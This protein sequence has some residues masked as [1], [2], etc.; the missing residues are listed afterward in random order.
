MSAEREICLITVPGGGGKR[1]T[2]ELTRR[3]TCQCLH[4]G[5]AAGSGYSPELPLATIREAIR[6][7]REFGVT[8]VYFTGGEPL[9]REDIYDIF[10]CASIDNAL[11]IYT[12]TNGDI[13]TP[14]V[15]KKLVECNLDGVLVSIDSPD[16]AEHNYFRQSANNFSSACA[17]VKTLKTAGLAV[18]IGMCLWG[19]TNRMQ[20]MVELAIELGADEVTFIW[21]VPVGRAACYA[22]DLLFSYEQYAETF[23]E[24]RV[25]RAKNAGK[26]RLSA[27]RVFD[28]A[29]CENACRGGI[30]FFHVDPEGRIS[31]CTWI[32]KIEPSYRSAKRL[33]EVSFDELAK[34][35]VI[36]GFRVLI[37]K[38]KMLHGGGCPAA[39]HSVCGDLM[40][41]DPYLVQR[42]SQ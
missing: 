42:G 31:P 30:D 14:D 4:C 29:A 28:S 24:I 18:E 20:G 12:A 11:N 22:K 32:E 8:H 13:V 6:G 38:I 10:R 16:E 26:I 25:L 39:S 40:G 35:D 34:G 21:A 36:Q 23:E 17:A 3:C 9:M 37:Q 7:M 41:E 33:G 15:A 5:I 1:V 27:H 2:W 19:K